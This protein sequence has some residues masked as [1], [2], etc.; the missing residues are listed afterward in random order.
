[1]N[2]SDALLDSES[3]FTTSYEQTFGKRPRT[4]RADMRRSLN[5][6]FHMAIERREARQKL[7]EEKKIDSEKRIR[8]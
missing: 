8:H 4:S 6:Q 5:E 1:M 3:C 2:P 7:I